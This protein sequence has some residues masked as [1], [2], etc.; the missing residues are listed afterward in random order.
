MPMR[1]KVLALGLVFT[2]AALSMWLTGCGDTRTRSVGVGGGDSTAGTLDNSTPPQQNYE[3][4]PAGPAT[5][6][7]N[8]PTNIPQPIPTPQSS[9]STGSISV[10]A[11]AYSE[12]SYP[13]NP[14][15]NYAR[16]VDIHIDLK[17]QL[18]P[19]AMSYRILRNDQS[20]Q[21]DQ[22]AALTTVS[23]GGL[24]AL[25]PFYWRQ[26][27]VPVV[28][29]LVPGEQYKYLIQAL[30]SSNQVIAQGTDETKPLYP[31]DVP[32]LVSPANNAAQVGI[33]PSFQWDAG[34]TPN[35]DGYF[36]EVYSGAYYVPMW[37]G[38]AAGSQAIALKYGQLGAGYPGTLPSIWTSILTPG[39]R[40]TWDVTAYKTDTGNAA[41]AKAFAE[42]NTPSWVFTP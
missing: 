30:N 41:T 28:S 3:P 24:N 4:Q 5:D 39:A 40:Y 38:F 18:Y 8:V 15:G 27:S 19:G 35:A 11:I 23:G 31:L 36:V 13:L 16:V 34:S 6:P 9:I 14:F 12:S 2:S 32:K 37:R 1:R 26:Y 29:P 33:Q 17:W 22:Y 10:S 20:M 21:P 7:G 25:M 42:S